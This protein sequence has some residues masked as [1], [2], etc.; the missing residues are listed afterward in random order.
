[1]T[2]WAL[3]EDLL[4]LCVLTSILCQQW[5]TNSN[6]Q[7]Q[8]LRDMTM[9]IWA[10]KGKMS[11][12]F[13]INCQCPLLLFVTCCLASLYALLTYPGCGRWS[14][15]GFR[16]C[17]QGDP[18]SSRSYQGW[19]EYTHQVSLFIFVVQ[20]NRQDM[21]NVWLHP[22]SLTSGGNRQ[23]GVFH[24]RS[25]RRRHPSSSH[26][27]CSQTTVSLSHSQPWTTSPLPRRNTGK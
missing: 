7:R 22:R 6:V 3:C 24:R 25:P 8:Q 5:W 21:L 20:R 9:Q 11:L 15:R 12:F 10:M 16:L 18:F 1:M 19:G 2:A 26:A 17:Q 13:I 27:C 23:C 4:P 14:A